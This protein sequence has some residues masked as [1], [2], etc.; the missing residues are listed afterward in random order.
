MNLN[1]G[2]DGHEG[3]RHEVWS[4]DAEPGHHIFSL[5]FLRQVL[6]ARMSVDKNAPAKLMCAMQML[7]V[8]F[9]VK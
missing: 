4:A 7:R 1:E 2:H 9:F 3:T 8:R 6:V 5:V